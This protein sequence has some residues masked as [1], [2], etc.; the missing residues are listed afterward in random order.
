MGRRLYSARYQMKTLVIG[1][2]FGGETA[3]GSII[4]NYPG[5]SHIDGFDLMLAMKKQV[6]DLEVE[7]VTDEVKEIQERRQLLYLH[8]PRGPIPEHGGHPCCGPW[9]A[10]SW[11]FP[12]SRTCWGRASP[13]ARPATPPLYR[14]QTV[15]VV[16]AGDAAIKGTVLLDKY[17]SRVYLIYRKDKLTR[18][19]PVNLAMLERSENVVQLAST[20]VTGLVGEE[21][22]ERLALDQPYDGAGEIDV[23]GLFIEIGA[24]PR[25]Q[26]AR[27]LGVMIN[28]QGEIMVSKMME[29]TVT[30]V[31]AAGD[32]TDATGELKQTITSTAQGVIA[33]TSAY[34][35]VSEHGNMCQMHAAGFE[36]AAV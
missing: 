10:A 2:E 12:T 31:F 25:N 19:E 21:K 20:N 29:T 24:D 35:Y 1:D 9:S 34:R 7:I 33:A 22:L 28:S 30:G 36:L 23:D 27:P 18:P 3:T 5:Y 4:E 16:G 15:A 32:V 17:A 6:E 14:G 8:C 13:T 11:A 26:L